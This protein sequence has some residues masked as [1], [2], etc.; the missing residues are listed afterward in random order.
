MKAGAPVS[1]QTLP[2]SDDSP[3]AR[4]VL[5]AVVSGVAG[6]LIQE[7]RLQHDPEQAQRLPPHATLCYLAPDATAALGLQIRR[8]FPHPVTVSLGDV[9]ELNNTDHTFYVSVENTQ[10]LDAARRRL[11][12]GTNL[13]LAG[14]D[15]WTWHVTCIR[16]GARRDLEE[17]RR[18][19]ASLKIEQPWTIDRIVLLELRADR[20]EERAAWHLSEASRP[21]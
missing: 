3:A 2:P 20:Y 13:K 9:H 12:D 1:I 18:I 6:D 19:T 14:P 15:T 7:F 21:A 4:R 17:A 11:F 10:E 5:A 16:Y 8:A